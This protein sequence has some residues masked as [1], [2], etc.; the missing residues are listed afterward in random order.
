MTG[1]PATDYGGSIPVTCRSVLLLAAA[2][3]IG[4]CA[5]NN[6]Y[7]EAR[8]R[9][10]EFNCDQYDV[11]NLPGFAEYFDAEVRPDECVLP[12]RKTLVGYERV[13]IY[14][15]ETGRTTS[16]IVPAGAVIVK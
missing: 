6:A 5:T 13:T 14:D 9:Y 12:P 7:L 4:G 3:L 1:V 16:A 10:E 11:V 2:V 15:A 8:K